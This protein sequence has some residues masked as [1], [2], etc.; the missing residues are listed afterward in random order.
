MKGIRNIPLWHKNYFGLKAIEKQPTL[1]LPKSRESISLCGGVPLA[2]HSCTKGKNDSS[3]LETTL[4]SHRP[5]DGTE[6]NL[7]YQNERPLCSISFPHMFTFSQFIAANKFKSFFFCLFVSPRLSFFV[8]MVRKPA[9]MTSSLEFL[10]H[11][12]ETFNIQVK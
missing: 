7:H 11:V 6:K 10:L 4:D 1:N 9:S 12:C 3:S 5:R 2:P 8:K